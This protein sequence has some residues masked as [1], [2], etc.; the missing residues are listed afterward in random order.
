MPFDGTYAETP[1]R[2]EF[3]PDESGG[4]A[5]GGNARIDGPREWLGVMSA[6]WSMMVDEALKLRT[7]LDGPAPPK[8]PVCTR[9]S[10]AGAWAVG[11]PSVLKP[12]PLGFEF[13][14]VRAECNGVTVP[15]SMV[16]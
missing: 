6:V 12:P 10:G 5:P 11:D 4:R 9:C 2:V 3:V 8:S 16:S 13:T 7:E 1:A 14:H 15:A